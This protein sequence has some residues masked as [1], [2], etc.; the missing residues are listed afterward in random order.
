MVDYNLDENLKNWQ[1]K[2]KEFAKIE[3]KPNAQECDK[4]N[5][6]DPSNP[7]PFETLKKASKEGIRTLTVPKEMGGEGLVIFAHLVLLEA[8]VAGEA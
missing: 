2:I 8:L 5:G 1:A 3:L 6:I 4:Q 7:F